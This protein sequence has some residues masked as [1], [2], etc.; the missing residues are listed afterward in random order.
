VSFFSAEIKEKLIKTRIPVNG[1]KKPHHR[2]V[3][4]SPNESSG[5]G[6]GNKNKWWS[7]CENCQFDDYVKIPPRAE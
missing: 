2:S 6:C 7:L 5:G 3:A 1:G 4:R